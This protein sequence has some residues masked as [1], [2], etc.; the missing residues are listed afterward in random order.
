MCI[1]HPNHTA[2]NA[3][4]FNSQAFILERCGCV[5]F[6]M[7]HEDGTK[8]CEELDCIKMEQRNWILSV[9]RGGDKI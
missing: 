7:P 3:F 9:S 1:I 4:I 2:N 8:I 6:S 5:K